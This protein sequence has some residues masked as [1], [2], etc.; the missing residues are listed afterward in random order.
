MKVNLQHP[1]G[2]NGG[3][4][5]AWSFCSHPWDQVWWSWERFASPNPHDLVVHSALNPKSKLCHPLRERERMSLLS[6]RPWLT[7]VRFRNFLWRHFAQIQLSLVFFSPHWVEGNRG[8]TLKTF[9]KCTART[10]SRSW[11]FSPHHGTL[12]WSS[13][14]RHRFWKLEDRGA[15]YHP[16]EIKNTREN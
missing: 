6:W 12:W 1:Q 10:I 9:P 11:N 8:C 15:S 7:Q 16:K 5:V 14:D 2:F 3:F 4:W 13:F